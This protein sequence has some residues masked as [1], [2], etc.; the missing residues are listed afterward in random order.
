[1]TGQRGSSLIEVLLAAAILGI[2]VVVLIGGLGTAVLSTEQHRGQASA[3]AY[4]RAAAEAVRGQSFQPCAGTSTYTLAGVVPV[5][6][7]NYVA[8]VTAL[9]HYTGSTGSLAVLSPCVP[10]IED[11][12]YVTL[13]ISTTDGRVTESVTIGMRRP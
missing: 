6:D 1:M 9:T 10:S 11:V 5:S 8:T 3:A 12:Q 13:A 4:L 2:A 7:A